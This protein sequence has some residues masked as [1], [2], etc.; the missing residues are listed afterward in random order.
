VANLMRVLGTAC[1]WH[2][3]GEEGCP[4][5]IGNA[6]PDTADKN[7]GEETVGEKAKNGA[8]AE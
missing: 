2:V 6:T 4:L 1:G 3:H 7:H 5:K 8:A